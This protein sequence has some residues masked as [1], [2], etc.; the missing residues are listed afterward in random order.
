MGHRDIK[1][2]LIYAK[3]LDSTKEKEIAKWNIY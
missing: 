2:T 3:I 1:T